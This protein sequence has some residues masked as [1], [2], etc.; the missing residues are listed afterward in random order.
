MINNLPA[1]PDKERWAG[2]DFI[3]QMANIGSEV[4]RTLKWKQKNNETLA[5]SAF[6]R[7]IDLFDLTIEVG[8][9]ESNPSY[10]D[11]M[12]REVLIARDLFSEE[13][14]SGDQNAIRGSERYFAHFAKACAIRSRR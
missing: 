4:G 13:Y 11:S 14:L 5:K 1:R 2:L 9:K 7:A 3:T 10:R 8:R 12:L 6:V